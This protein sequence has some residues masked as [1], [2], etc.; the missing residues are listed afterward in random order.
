MIPRTWSP[1]PFDRHELRMQDYSLSDEQTLIRDSLREFFSQKCPT[2]RVREAGRL[3][4][5][6]KLWSELVAF[7]VTSMALPEA[8]GGDGA[9]LVDLVI[10]ADEIGRAIAP[11]PFISHVTSI[12]LLAQLGADHT[13]ME[14]ATQG[15][16]LLTL[17]P[18]PVGACVPQLVPDA[19]VASGVVALLDTS[20]VL[21]R[22]PTPATHV[23]NQGDTPLGWW[24][25]ANRA[26]HV[27]LAS[28]AEA[29]QAYDSAI[30]ERLLLT[31]A[32]LVGM[33]EA[34][35]ERAVEF[36]KNR[37]TLGIPI[38]ALQ[39]VAYPLVDIAIDITAAR[40]LVRRAA[41]MTANESGVRPELPAMAFAYASRT[42]TR[43]TTNAAHVQ[44]GLGFT[45]EADA[46]LY[47][48]RAKGWSGVVGS[49][50]TDLQHIGELILTRARR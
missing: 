7:G 38:G 39:G 20:V 18:H 25:P 19:A 21:H 8:Y 27:T 46:S 48:L 10:V 13:I 37:M 50:P 47:F 33:T 22:L 36:A 26:E 5:D 23:P 42:A 14:P 1:V 40:N 29:A 3:G 30:A 28:G 12:R 11:V 34:A 17:P 24:D 44:G 32:A 41:W 43:G 31:A 49:A 15:D 16:L 6:Q 45:A 2:S 4:F 35:L 9:T